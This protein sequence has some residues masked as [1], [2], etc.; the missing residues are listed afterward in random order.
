MTAPAPADAPPELAPDTRRA[1]PRDDATFIAW[2]Q[3]VGTNPD[4]PGGSL[5]RTVDLSPEGVGLI[6]PRAFAAGDLVRID[7]FVHSPIQ[8]RATGHVRHCTP[9][10]DGFRLGVALD[11]APYLVRSTTPEEN[12]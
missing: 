7:F 4:R 8:L 10:E 9:C 5:A 2:V 12:L 1:V 6:I 11:G 3:Y